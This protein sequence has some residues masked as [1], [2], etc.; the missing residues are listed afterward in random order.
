MTTN[1]R[2][3]RQ[4]VSSQA[5]NQLGS[6]GGLKTFLRGGQIFWTMSNNFKRC[7]I[8]FSRGAK[9]ISRGGFVSLRPPWLRTC[10]EPC[11][12]NYRPHAIVGCVTSWIHTMIVMHTWMYRRNEN[13]NFLLR[14]K[15][16][17]CLLHNTDI[18][19]LSQYLC[20]LKAQHL[21]QSPNI[22]SG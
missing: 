8:H 21:L 9:K 4:D 7:P 3:P 14:S 17:A 12:Q 13:I 11:N 19:V 5:R 18:V 16:P 22:C 6:L 10:I 20:H 1:T 2:S 15:P